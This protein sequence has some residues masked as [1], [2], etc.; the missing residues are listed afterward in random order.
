MLFVGLRAPSTSIQCDA[1][2]SLTL[3]QDVKTYWQ[4]WQPVSAFLAPKPRFAVTGRQEGS[5]RIFG[6]KPPQQAAYPPEGEA[7]TEA[8]T[9]PKPTKL[10]PSFGSGSLLQ[11]LNKPTE[12]TPV[13]ATQA[14]QPLLPKVEIKDPR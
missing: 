5:P 11:G 12:A 9:S 8:A 1:T 7:L 14:P 3:W 4:Q 6:Q 2:S 13:E 10:V